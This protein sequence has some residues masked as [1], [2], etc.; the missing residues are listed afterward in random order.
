MMFSGKAA[1]LFSDGRVDYFCI[2]LVGGK[3]LSEQKNPNSIESGF[4][5]VV[6]LGLEPRT[7]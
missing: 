5:I 6:P 4:L 3:E 1:H 2:D 7:P